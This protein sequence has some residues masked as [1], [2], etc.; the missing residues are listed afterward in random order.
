MNNV[1]RQQFATSSDFAAN[2]D[3]AARDTYYID[4]KEFVA[5]SDDNDLK[6]EFRTNTAV[7]SVEAWSIPRDDYH[8]ARKIKGMYRAIN[9]NDYKPGDKLLVS[10]NYLV[11]HYPHVFT[12]IVLHDV[13][14]DNGGLPGLEPTMTDKVIVAS[15]DAHVAELTA[16]TNQLTEAR[17]QLRNVGH[18][19]LNTVAEKHAIAA[20]RDVYIQELNRRNDT[21]NSYIDRLMEANVSMRRTEM[22]LKKAEEELSKQREEHKKE[23]K[24]LKDENV[25]KHFIVSKLTKANNSL[26]QAVKFLWRKLN[27]PAAV[28]SASS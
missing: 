3:A 5:K 27:R 6:K 20:E 14:A 11:R 1:N 12:N 8:Y 26:E 4:L 15:N 28:T 2:Q 7:R 18:T 24:R 23:L 9:R 13:S 19:L 10:Q 25:K 17:T 22:Q 21:M 16:L